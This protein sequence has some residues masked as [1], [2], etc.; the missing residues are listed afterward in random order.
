MLQNSQTTNL[1]AMSCGDS[2]LNS[3]SAAD[4]A[5]DDD[6]IGSITSSTSIDTVNTLPDISLHLPAPNSKPCFQRSR[7]THAKLTLL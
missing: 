2:E 5:D 6:N 3:G 4:S 7:F 1:A